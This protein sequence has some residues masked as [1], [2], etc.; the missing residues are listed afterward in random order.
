MFLPSFTP[1]LQFTRTEFCTTYGLEPH[2]RTIHAIYI[3]HDKALASL[4]PRTALVQ[5]SVHDDAF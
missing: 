4:Q 3:K 2:L 5:G 1:R